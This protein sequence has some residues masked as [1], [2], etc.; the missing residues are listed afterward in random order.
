MELR[1][2][3]SGGEPVLRE[4]RRVVQI[5]R[6]VEEAAGRVVVDNFEVFVGGP[7]AEGLLPGGLPR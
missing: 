7:E 1:S 5:Q 6:L 4:E 2:S 3:F